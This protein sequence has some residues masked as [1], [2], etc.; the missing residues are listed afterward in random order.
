MDLKCFRYGQNSYFATNVIS[1]MAYAVWR[2]MTPLV[3][4]IALIIALCLAGI[5]A[6]FWAALRV[7]SAL[8]ASSEEKTGWKLAR[9]SLE[10]NAERLSTRLQEEAQRLATEQE[11]RKRERETA[12]QERDAKDEQ[13]HEN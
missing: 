12:T 6:R 2:A 8:R 11:S 4:I 13:P 1:G 10:Q 9:A 7:Q 3:F 5:A